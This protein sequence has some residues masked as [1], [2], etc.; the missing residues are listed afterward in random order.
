M[1]TR[2]ILNNTSQI[3]LNAVTLQVNHP[4]TDISRYVPDPIMKPDD[5]YSYHKSYSQN[6]K[7]INIDQ[8]ELLYSVRGYNNSHVW[9]SLNGLRIPKMKMTSTPHGFNAKEKENDQE[10]ISEIISNQLLWRGVSLGKTEYGVTGGNQ[11]T[12]LIG[13][14][15]TLINNGYNDL[16]YG[17]IVVWR[18][19][20][21]YT[22]L[23][24]TMPV[25][26]DHKVTLVLAPFEKEVDRL[27]KYYQV[28]ASK[29][30]TNRLSA[31]TNILQRKI[32][33]CISE[34]SKRGERVDI[35]LRN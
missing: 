28:G 18:V 14:T 33:T 6:T 12:S 24:K 20:H 25:S 11:V 17:D 27:V 30:F 2:D 9:S 4:V 15:V 5:F 31:Y 13:G 16:N 1:G 22:V 3:L 26:E 10:H 29:K 7:T 21:D 35:L 8:Y 19:P 34:S 23:G 32:G